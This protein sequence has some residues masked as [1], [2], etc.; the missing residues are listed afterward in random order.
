M[1]E[2]AAS[3]KAADDDVQRLEDEIKA[4]RMPL[5]KEISEAQREIRVS[6]PK[7]KRLTRDIDETTALVADLSVPRKYPTS[8][9]S[10][11]IR[12]GKSRTTTTYSMRSETTSERQAREADL[13]AAK[14]KLTQLQASQEYSSSRYDEALRQRSELKAETKR[15]TAELAVELTAAKRKRL[16][17]GARAKVA[18]QALVTPEKIQS[19][20]TALETYLPF[21]PAT[22]RSRLLATLKPPAKSG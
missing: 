2:I 11:S 18:E 22:E 4:I 15:A 20:L 1:E 5:E 12:M 13:A 3:I 14:E 17:L 19:R 7:V 8:S 6:G 16:D 9:T 21:D 10:S